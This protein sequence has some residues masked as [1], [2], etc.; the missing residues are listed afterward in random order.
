MK[1]IYESKSFKEKTQFSNIEN[2]I[3]EISVSN[4]ETDLKVPARYI[5]DLIET[6]DKDRSN[7]SYEQNLNGQSSGYEL[8]LDL[9]D[10]EIRYFSISVKNS[11]KGTLEFI[12]KLRK[13]A[14]GKK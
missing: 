11:D 13:E 6:L 9:S 4:S 10:K 12:E 2:E 7:M 3:K 5:D 14:K 1:Y 8:V